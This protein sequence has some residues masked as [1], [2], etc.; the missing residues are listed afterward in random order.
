MAQVAPP[1][2]VASDHFEWSLHCAG[3]TGF[4][5][6][7]SRVTVTHPEH[8]ATVWILLFA[9]EYLVEC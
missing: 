3:V 8:F 5:W 6:W 2:L 1:G 7:S 9:Q 4:R